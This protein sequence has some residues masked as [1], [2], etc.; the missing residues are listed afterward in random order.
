MESLLQVLKNELNFN[1]I[2][3]NNEKFV[4]GVYFIQTDI[5]GIIFLFLNAFY[6]F[7]LIEFRSSKKSF[8]SII[9]STFDNP[10]DRK[11]VV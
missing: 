4:L 11:S 7:L 10:I 2:K 6:N 9:L 5:V 1:I 8:L 3:E